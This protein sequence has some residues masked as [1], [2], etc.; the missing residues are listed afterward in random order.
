MA[1][2]FEVRCKIKHYIRFEA[3][4]AKVRFGSKRN[5]SEPEITFCNLTEPCLTELKSNVMLIF[6]A[7]LEN[8]GEGSPF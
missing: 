5:L 4:F 6:A 2:I 7:N 8:I 1:Y 3:R